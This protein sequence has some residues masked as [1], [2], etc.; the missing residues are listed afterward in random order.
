MY[1]CGFTT[2]HRVIEH[3]HESNEIAM[4]LYLNGRNHIF[5]WKK[6]LHIMIKCKSCVKSWIA[7]SILVVFDIGDWLVENLNRFPVYIF[8]V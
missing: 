7:I 1:S 5:I 8:F 4:Q 3:L 2:G 6:I